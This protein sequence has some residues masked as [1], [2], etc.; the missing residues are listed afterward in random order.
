MKKFDSDQIFIQHDFA[1][2]STIFFFAFDQH[3]QHFIQHLNFLMLGEMLDRFNST[4][5]FG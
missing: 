4:L 3:I 1:L 5:T 2:S